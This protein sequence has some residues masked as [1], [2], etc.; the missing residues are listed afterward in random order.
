[1]KRTITRIIAMLWLY[2]YEINNETKLDDI[3]NILGEDIVYDEKFL[4][5]LIDGV[6]TNIDEID[7]IISIYIKKYTIDRLNIV[8]KNLVRIGVYELKYLKTPKSIIINEIVEISKE[9]SEVENYDSSK[10]NNSLLD[11]IAKGLSDGR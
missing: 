1:M 6:L 9:Y 8:D 11:A 4:L 7:H 3:I 10:F 2:S 5:Q